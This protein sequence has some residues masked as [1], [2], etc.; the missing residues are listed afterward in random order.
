MQNIL[1][2]SSKKRLNLSKFCQMHLSRSLARRV[3]FPVSRFYL[4]CM[5]KLYY[6]LN[7][8]E[9][10]L[11]C[12]AITQ[13]FEPRMSQSA[14]SGLIARTFRGIF[15]HYQE[16]LFLAYA[17][18]HRVKAELQQRLQIRGAT[19]LKNALDRG[20]GVILATGHFGAVEF[21]P[22]ALALQGWPAAIIVRPQTKELA[23]SLTSRAALINLKLIFP[24]HGKV[25][26][27]ALKSLREGRILI[28][29]CDEFE[30]WR[31]NSEQSVDFLGFHLPSDRT[32]N[33]LQKR[34][35]APVLTALVRREPKRQYCV[36]LAGVPAFS[37]T[38]ET[39]AHCLHRLQEEIFRH[40]EQWY[41]WKEFG[42]FIAAL[43]AHCPPP[44]AY[45]SL[46]AVPCAL[47]CAVL[48][49]QGG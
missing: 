10:D 11:I 5:G 27:A 17:P 4:S 3:P 1:N 21:L 41:Q 38:R 9:R 47:N 30:Q 44:T 40:P 18:V 37:S 42:R 12:H 28:T 16:K 48:T 46:S 6:L 45:R 25:L 32:L 49:T 2:R 33:V 15:T 8:Q 19:E 22:G 43:P 20:C 35:G 13:V 39:S 23:A 26:P 31:L 36:Q 34:S 14:L 7:P 29:E 24:E